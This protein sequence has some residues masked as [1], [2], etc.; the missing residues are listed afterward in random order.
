MHAPQSACDR[1]NAMYRHQRFI[2][3]LTRRYYLL[4]RDQMLA[5]L[6]VPDGG[7]VLEIGCGTGRN[8]IAAAGIYPSAHLFGLD[9]S[10]AMLTTAHRSVAR[11][12]LA[13]RIDLREADATNLDAAATFGVPQFERVFF[14]YAL[15]MIPPW[16]SALERAWACVAVGGTLHVVDFGGMERLPRAFSSG[17]RGWLARFGV[18]PRETLQQTL[19]EL[20]GRSAG[21][22][23]CQS[24]YG[25][26]A[27]LAALHKG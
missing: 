7:R 14:S 17:M 10:T 18:T 2:Y 3:D 13:G 21:R 23:H 27:V 26:Y 16:Q 9:V 12:G 22:L 4:G 1:M 20:V 24:H 19:T 25:G 5:S 8:L 15:S 6:A 11:K